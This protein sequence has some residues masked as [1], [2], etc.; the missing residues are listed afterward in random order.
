MKQTLVVFRMFVL[1]HYHRRF[2]F[3]VSIVRVVSGE[4]KFSALLCREFNIFFENIA[5]SVPQD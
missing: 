5:T 1:A 2:K 3:W 4:T